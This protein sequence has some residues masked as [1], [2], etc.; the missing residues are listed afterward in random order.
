M[1]KCFLVCL[2]IAILCK[3]LPYILIYLDWFMDGQSG[4]FS[5]DKG[6]FIVMGFYTLS[7]L[8][9]ILVFGF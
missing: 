5:E 3:E 6:Y 4:L 2:N 8:I 1:I 7:E 9:L